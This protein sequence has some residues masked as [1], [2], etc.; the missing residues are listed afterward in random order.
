LI[1]NWK[2]LRK[3]VNR[4]A[5]AANA[6]RRLVETAQLN[7]VRQWGTL[8]DLEVAYLVALAERKPA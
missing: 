4:E 6:Y 3:W 8:T 7:E 1:R 5:D 2:Q